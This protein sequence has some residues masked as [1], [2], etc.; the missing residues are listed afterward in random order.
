MPSRHVSVFYSP[1]ISLSSSALADATLSALKQ[2]VSNGCNAGNGFVARTSLA[3]Q[4]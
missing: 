4:K 2:L 3:G 1:P